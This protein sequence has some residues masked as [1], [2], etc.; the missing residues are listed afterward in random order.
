MKLDAL[1]QFTALR[2]QLTQE[3]ERL[4]SRIQEIDNVFGNHASASPTPKAHGTPVRNTRAPRRIKN[5]ISLKKAVIKVT[6]KKPLTKPEIL[7]AVQK[8]GWSTT[9]KNPRKLLDL[10][11]YGKNPKFKNQNGKF[12][13]A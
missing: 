3:R 8:L 11:L 7:A 13:P 5:P 12:S 10:L 1:K 6:T 4:A 2:N 9:S